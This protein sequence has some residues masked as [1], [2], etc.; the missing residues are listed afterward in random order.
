MQPSSITSELYL[1]NLCHAKIEYNNNISENETLNEHQDSTGL[2]FHQEIA[3]KITLSS[4][5]FILP[6]DRPLVPGRPDLL[7][8]G[9]LRHGRDNHGN[10][11]ICRLGAVPVP[12]QSLVRGRLGCCRVTPGQPT[13]QRS[14]QPGR[15]PARLRL[16]VGSQVLNPWTAAVLQHISAPKPCFTARPAWAIGDPSG[17]P[18]PGQGRLYHHHCWLALVNI[19]S[20]SN[21]SLHARDHWFEPCRSEILYA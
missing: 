11:A 14:T 12:A 21:A 15:R 4:L 2:E 1:S 13:V 16:Q 18:G 6:S 3:E 5:H 20:L 7:P 19:C 9:P 17:G 10:L 8:L